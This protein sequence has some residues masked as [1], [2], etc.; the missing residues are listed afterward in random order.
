MRNRA[1]CARMPIVS[2]P[3]E[4]SQPLPLSAREAYAWSTDYRSDDI[5]LLG[6]NGRRRIQHLANDT[7][8]L[9]DTFVSNDGTRVSKKKL[10]RLYPSRLMFTN[11]HVSGP[12]QHSQFIYEFL[13]EGKTG[14]TL[15]FTGQQ[16]V[17]VDRALS[18][19]EI[20]K[21]AAE[22]RKDDHGTWKSLAKAMKP[23]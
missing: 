7:I 13:D 20:R 10:V 17:Q 5:A 16:I 9:T 11:T 15:R 2:L 12:N 3:F 19:A 6:G 4:F 22:A 18:S 8:L 21:R 23:R 14:S 1:I